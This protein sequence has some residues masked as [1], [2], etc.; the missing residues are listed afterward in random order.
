MK[1]NLFKL[2]ATSALTATL[3][4]QGANI[5]LAASTEL[6][7]SNYIQNGL[8]SSA[9]F[10]PNVEGTSTLASGNRVIVDGKLNV[11]NNYNFGNF[12]LSNS[13]VRINW[14]PSSSSNFTIY[15]ASVGSNGTYQSYGSTSFSSAGSKYIKG[16]PTGIPLFFIVDGRAVGSIGAYDWAGN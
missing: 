9:S 10:I 2:L 1:S 16:L 15:V 14:I 13:T 8:I 12:T 7:S 4:L 5:T 11:S 3:L 6:D